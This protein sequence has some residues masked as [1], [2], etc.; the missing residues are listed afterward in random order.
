ML[1]RLH[2]P[3]LASLPSASDNVS[4]LPSG[5]T[6]SLF[7]PG[8]PL[9]TRHTV[10]LIRPRPGLRFIVRIRFPPLGAPAFSF[11]SVVR[12]NPGSSSAVMRLSLS[13]A[14]SHFAAAPLFERFGIMRG[15]NWISVSRGFKT[16]RGSSL[17]YD[18][19]DGNMPRNVKHSTKPVFTSLSGP[20][21]VFE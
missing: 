21:M 10:P 4:S 15:T 2:L 12:W 9:R 7:T 5:G 13:G 19:L 6:R 11:V 20:E 18:R 8:R 17:C 14:R 16:W 3:H 1:T